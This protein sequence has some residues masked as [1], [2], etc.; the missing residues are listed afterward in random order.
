MQDDRNF[1]HTYYKCSFLTWRKRF[2][3]LDG[4]LDGSASLSDGREGRVDLDENSKC[5]ILD[6]GPAAFLA[7]LA[8]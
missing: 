4:Y 3:S 2:L 8:L 1:G 5:E 6:E 7:K